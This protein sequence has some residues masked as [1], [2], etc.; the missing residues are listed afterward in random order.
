[1]APLLLDE[2]G[3][4]LVLLVEEVQGLLVARRAIELILV[5]QAL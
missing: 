2:P 1:M 5:D 3:E 4:H